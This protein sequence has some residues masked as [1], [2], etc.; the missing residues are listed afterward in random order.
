M[1]FRVLSPGAFVLR[2]EHSFGSLARF[3]LRGRQGNE[4]RRAA[5]RSL[6]G[7][8]RNPGKRDE[9]EFWPWCCRSFLSGARTWIALRFIQAREARNGPGLQWLSASLVP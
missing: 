9:S 1:A 4:D 2:V 7:A 8:R 6:D 3:L 5:S